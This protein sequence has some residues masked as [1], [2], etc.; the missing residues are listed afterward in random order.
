MGSDGSERLSDV[1]HDRTQPT[2][3]K[4]QSPS[5]RLGFHL[6]SITLSY[7]ASERVARIELLSNVASEMASSIDTKPLVS[8][9][10]NAPHL[11]DHTTGDNHDTQMAGYYVG[12]DIMVH[13]L[14]A[15]SEEART[16]E[17]TEKLIPIR[18]VIATFAQ[19]YYITSYNIFLKH[20]RKSINQPL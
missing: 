5:R 3:M 13:E 16:M 17:T 11:W 8:L 14:G 15:Q 6:E 7:N 12:Q 18:H 1:L 20:F 4:S 19:Q 9:I 2:E 10:Q